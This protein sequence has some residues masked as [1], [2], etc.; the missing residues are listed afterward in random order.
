MSSVGVVAEFNPFHNGHAYALNE[1]RRVSGAENVVVCMSGSFVQRGEPAC[2]DKFTRTKHALLGGADLVIELPDILSCACAEIFAFGGVKLLLSTGIVDGIAFGSECADTEQLIYSAKRDM[3]SDSIRESLERGESYAKAAASVCED[4][5]R[6]GPN[7]ILA[8]EYIRRML[9]LAP[10]CG[11]Y[12]FRRIGDYNDLDLG[13]H[14]SSASAIRAAIERNEIDS[15]KDCLPGFVF[16]D[17]AGGIVSGLFPASL[18]SLSDAALYAFRNMSVKDISALPDVSEGLENLFSMHANASSTVSE[19][20]SKVKSKRYTMAR[21]KR[22]VI[23]ALI[24]STAE[25]LSTVRNA[26]DSLYIRV[27]GVRREKLYLL[28][29]LSKNA[30]LP[31]V[32]SFADIHALGPTARSVIEISRKASRIRALAQPSV[33]FAKDDFSHP[34]VIV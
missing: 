30:R 17:I 29:E 25:F 4:E 21:L 11:I 8:V 16:E 1:A 2:F 5:Q 34:L 33:K 13:G 31:I 9:S 10:D 14:Y 20:L 18:D 3:H 23:S 6:I 22:I 32:A 24:G 15:V 19:V 7:D 26:P 28:S 12:P 27:L